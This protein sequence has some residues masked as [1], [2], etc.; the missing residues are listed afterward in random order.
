MN[1]D[2]FWCCT[3]SAGVRPSVES[4]KDTADDLRPLCKFSERSVLKTVD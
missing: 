1:V 3:G 4:G 2:S